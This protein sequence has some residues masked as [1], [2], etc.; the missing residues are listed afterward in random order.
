M[1]D[2]H[3]HKGLLKVLWGF[4]CQ[5]TFL[6]GLDSGSIRNFSQKLTSAGASYL[7]S[8]SRPLGQPR[9][10]RRQIIVTLDAW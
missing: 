2:A 1:E 3:L 5:I 9:L 4:F 8:A 6:I 7:H 10:V